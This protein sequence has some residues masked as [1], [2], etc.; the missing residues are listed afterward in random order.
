MKKGKNKNFQR[1]DNKI[2]DAFVVLLKQ[3]DENKISITDLCEEANI[4]RT[5]FYMHYKG[6]WEVAEELE[7]R[8]LANIF[9]FI[10]QNVSEIDFFER[11]EFYFRKLNDFLSN[12][13]LL[14]KKML[15]SIHIAHFSD[16]LRDT[17]VSRYLEIGE[18]KEQLNSEE[19]IK[20]FTAYIA[21]YTGAILNLYLSY[22]RSSLCC[23]LDC[24]AKRAAEVTKKLQYFKY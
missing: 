18:I 19:K 20:D 13:L 21:A 9:A 4:N 12:D 16:K 3:R 8:E 22:F 11:A 24:V 15:S 2:I 23:D 6:M 7:D 17:I 1:I 5:T 14:T 10:E